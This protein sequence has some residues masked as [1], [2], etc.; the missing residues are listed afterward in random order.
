MAD[1]IIVVDRQL[2]QGHAM[3]M[4]EAPSHFFVGPD[5]DLKILKE[6]VSDDEMKEVE[7]AVDYCPNFAL[8]LERKE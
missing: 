7:A 1:F 8:R 5:G 6:D 2:C 4:G 3:C